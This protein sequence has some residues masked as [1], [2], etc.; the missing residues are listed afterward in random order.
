[1][2]QL[3]IKFSPGVGRY[4]KA[5]YLPTGDYIRLPNQTLIYFFSPKHALDYAVSIYGETW[6]KTCSFLIWPVLKEHFK[7]ERWSQDGLPTKQ[8]M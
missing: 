3:S 2:C 5:L 1:M 8:P 6:D 7:F 4:Y